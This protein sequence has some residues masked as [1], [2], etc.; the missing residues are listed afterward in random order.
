MYT[1][2]NR[3][4]S[5]LAV[6]GFVLSIAFLLALVFAPP[7][8]AVTE[9]EH[10]VNEAQLTLQRLLSDENLGNMPDFLNRARAVYIVPAL[11][12]GGFVLGAE[13]GKGVLLA[14]G[15]DGTWSSPAFVTTAGGSIGLQ[16]GGQVSEVVF[17]IM[18]DEA[19]LAILEDNFK[20]GGDLS[21]A[22]GPLGA[23]IE[24]GTTTNFDADVYAFSHAVGLFGGGSLEGSAMLIDDEDNQTY[25]GNA[26]PPEAILLERRF[27]NP[28]SEPLRKLLP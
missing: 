21:I 27:N 28:Q 26:A 24:A 10:L 13:G 3:R 23:G 15:T 20:M 12:K 4:R 25:Y 19:L 9:Q 5:L 8:R 18:N 11:F 2:V 22:V 6:A 1:T 17:T 16:I 14:K 7:A